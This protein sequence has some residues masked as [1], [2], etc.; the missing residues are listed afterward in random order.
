[1]LRDYSTPKN[2]K[3]FEVID[4]GRVSTDNQNE[5]SRRSQRYSTRVHRSQRKT[6]GINT[7]LPIKLKG[8]G[9]TAGGRPLSVISKPDLQKRCRMFSM[10]LVRHA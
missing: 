8:R 7:C 4:F 1:M 2:G 6:P 3:A 9:G 10:V 5:E